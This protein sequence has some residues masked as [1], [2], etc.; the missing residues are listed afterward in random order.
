[1]VN[2][3]KSATGL[4]SE[5]VH[6]DSCRNLEI[7]DSDRWKK[8]S[9]RDTNRFNRPPPSLDFIDRQDVSNCLVKMPGG[10]RGR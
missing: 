7:P 9:P 3:S 2:P 6:G 10:R 4:V 1:V 8:S 5:V